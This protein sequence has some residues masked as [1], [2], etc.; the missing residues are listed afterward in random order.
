MDS[1]SG[2]GTSLFW[3]LHKSQYVPIILILCKEKRLSSTHRK[4]LNY[5]DNVIIAHFW[6]DF[7]EALE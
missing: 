1:N 7:E 2:S 5:I 3:A 4:I 6:T